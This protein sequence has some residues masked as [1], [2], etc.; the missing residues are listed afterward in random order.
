MQKSPF[1][2]IYLNRTVI[3]MVGPPGFEPGTSTVS[4]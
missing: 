4:R 2:A 3:F 1:K